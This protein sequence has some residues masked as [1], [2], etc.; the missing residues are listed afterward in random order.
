MDFSAQIVAL[1][2]T[3]V[4]AAG[5]LY[6]RVG[7]IHSTPLV[8]TLISLIVQTVVV[9]ALLL[10]KGGIPG[11]NPRALVVFVGVGAVLPVVRWLSYMGI[12]RIGS[13]RASSLR[14][15]HP[16][17]SAALAIA[18]LGEPAKQNIMLGTVLIVVGIF[19]TCWEPKAKSAGAKVSDVLFPLSAAVF[20]GFIHPFTRYALRISNEPVLFSAVVGLTSLLC[21]G[22]YFL[23]TGRG[24]TVVWPNRAALVP[25]VAASLFETVGFL[26]FSA[27]VSL[28]QVVLIA[29]IM[30][31]TPIWVLLGSLV[32]LRDLD[33]VTLRTALG[34][35]AVVGGTVLLTLN[36]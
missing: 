5:N 17:F 22:G 14:S 8:V 16:F 6:A 9:W 25:F 13:A 21:L 26:L 27:A 1:A 34:T 20:S 11:A 36:R 31:T 29:P 19:L 35:C 33:K 3:A 18:F 4:Y 32:L 2:S 10:A 30:A 24:K 12:A 15:T 23:I 28:G 7:L